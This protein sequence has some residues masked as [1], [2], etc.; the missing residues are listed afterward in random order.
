MQRNKISFKGQKIYIGIDVHAK[1]WEV[2]V[3]TESG[4]KERH[5]QKASAKSLFD[6][7]KK[8]FPDGEY[9]AVYE[10]GFSGF[11]TYYALKEFGIGCVVTHAA[12]VPTS[13]YEEIM[14]TDKVD[15]A[16]LARSLRAGDIRSIYIRERENIDDRSVVRIRKTIQK[17]LS[18]YKARVKHMLHCNGVEMPER[19]SKQGSHWSKDFIKW[20]K[21]DVK[22]LSSSRLSL[23]LLIKQVETIRLNLLDAT[24]AMRNLGQTQRYRSNYD[25][26]MSIPGIG[27]SVAMCI[28]TEIYDV[29]RF[30]NEN[31]FA[32]YL[33][34]IPTCHNSGE[35]TSSGEKTFRGNKHLGPMII[36]AAWIAIYKDYGLG[37]A[38]AKYK[39]SM[40]PQKAI[41]KV[42][43]KMS[44]IIFSVLKNGK[45]YEPYKW[46]K[47]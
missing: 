29:K 7:L 36:E 9:H 38:Y 6:F 44:N 22:L 8:H 26:L 10:S 20:L 19:F 31:Q 5:P 33:G 1:T 2:A 21:E 45:K 14:K 23:D 39:Q 40:K 43:R 17:Q 28:L 25:L 24:R 41:V 47:E 16:K 32:S 35:K 46:D 30:H 13:Q 12:D 4:Y 11:S 3:L 34:L 15:A 42:A 37:M 18:G 27:V